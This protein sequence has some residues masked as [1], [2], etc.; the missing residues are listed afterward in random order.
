MVN[1]VR[2]KIGPLYPVRPEIQNRPRCRAA[3]DSKDIKGSKDF[4]FLKEKEAKR[5]SFVGLGAAATGEAHKSL[6]VR[7]KVG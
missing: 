2:T 3:K 5:T 1:P 6:S 7:R 4:F